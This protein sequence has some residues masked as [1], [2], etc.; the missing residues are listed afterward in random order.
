[1]NSIFYLAF[2]F[3][4][5]YIVSAGDIANPGEVKFSKLC[6]DVMTHL[7]ENETCSYAYFEENIKPLLLECIERG[8]IWGSTGKQEETPHFSMFLSPEIAGY[9]NPFLFRVLSEFLQS[10][11]FRKGDSHLQQETCFRLIEM[12]SQDEYAAFHP[13]ILSMVFNHFYHSGYYDENSRRL[14]KKMIVENDL[15]NTPRILLLLLFFPEK[16]I[17][18][19]IV[20]VLRKHAETN[21]VEQ[22]NILPWIS[23]V[24]LA[25]F[26]DQDAMDILVRVIRSIDNSA[27]GIELAAYMFPCL[28]LVQEPRIVEEMTLL[29]ADEKIIDQ[30]DDI[31][32]R[33]T[34]LSF[35]A[36]NVLYAMIEDYPVFSRYDFNGRERRK[37]L[38]WMMKNKKYKFRKTDCRNNDPVIRQTH[39]MIFQQK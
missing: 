4:F 10:E 15:K 37:C 8:E 28:T 30:G 20:S 14:I 18:S 38:D 31:L 21:K 3:F 11:R 27:Y 23:L 16:D 19:D 34:G 2:S 6:R 17:S 22:N 39:Y 12:L 5:V 32:Q 33:Y 1:M 35:I 9:E 7:K 26:K 25:K 36:A 13:F 24:L 29:L